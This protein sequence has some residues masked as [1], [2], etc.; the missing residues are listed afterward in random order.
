MMTSIGRTS[1]SWHEPINVMALAWAFSITLVILFVLCGLVAL[2]VPN[3]PLAH[4]WLDL[5]TKAPNG[6][7]RSFIEGLIGSIVFG[8]ITALIL[9]PIYNRLAR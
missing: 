4:G 8:W 2:A 9:G 6:T 5:F 7:V 3:T 1:V